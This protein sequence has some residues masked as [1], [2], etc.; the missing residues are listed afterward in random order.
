[1]I[2]HCKETLGDGTIRYKDYEVTDPVPEEEEAG[3]EDYEQ[4][5]QEMGVDFDD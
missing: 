1:M 5:L 4:A 3:I 2:I